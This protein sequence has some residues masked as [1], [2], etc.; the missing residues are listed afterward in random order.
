MEYEGIVYRPPSE[1]NSLIVQVTIGCS[2]NACSFCTMYSSKSF[3]IKPLAIIIE[4]LKTFRK[5]YPKVKRIFLADG[6]AFILKTKDLLEILKT[7]K[8][9]F[10][11]CERVSSYTTPRD[12]LNKT[13]EELNTLH[14]HGLT[15]LYMGIES[16]CDTVLKAVNKGVS[17][18]EIIEAG[19]KVCQ[20]EMNLSVTLISGLGG[21]DNWRSHAIESAHV[22]SEIDPDYVGLLTLMVDGDSSMEKLIKK[23]EM[24]LLTPEEVLKETYEL[25]KRLH[26]K[27]CIFRS[28][29][30]SNYVSLSGT[31]NKDKAMLLEKLNSYMEDSYDFKD[32]RFRGL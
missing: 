9:V 2:H 30:A 5:L 16:G 32:E 3:R 6:D 15:L 10:P 17:S 26:V 13:L 21:R 1:A 29:H 22:I 19:Q 7:I 24:V 31:L 25:I 20:S 12:V 28:N 4:E 27:E 11:E 14:L 23:G 8:I 18:I